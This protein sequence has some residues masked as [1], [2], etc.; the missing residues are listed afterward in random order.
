MLHGFTCRL[1]GIR[2]MDKVFI[3]GGERTPVGKT[4]GMLN[5]FLPE[6]LA[7]LVLNGVID[8][9][10][11]SP[12]EVDHVI[13]G[14]VW[15]PGGNIAR[16]S[17]LEAGWPYE[18]PGTTIDFQCGSGLSAVTIGANQI[19]A[20]Q[21]DLVIAGGVESSSMAPVRKFNVRD[22]RFRGEGFYERAPFSIPLVGDPEMG[23]GAE[24]LAGLMA[25]SREEMDRLA[26]ES[27][28]RASRTQNEGLLR[29]II[30]P[31]NVNGKMVSNDECIRP[32]MNMRLLERMPAAF[33]QGGKV[34][35]GNACLK[36]DGA[37]AVLLASGRAI[38]K[39]N[40][41]PEAVILHQAISGCDPN[42]FPLGPVLSVKKALE[43]ANKKL[44]EI[45]AFEINE[46]F[47]VKVLACCQ[48][49]SISL[50]KT[51]ILGG[52]LAYGHPYG[53]SGAIILLHLL[54][55]LRKIN[56]RLGIAAIGAAGGQ[57][58]AV[59]VERCC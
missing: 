23:Q 39:F 59:L 4:G 57:G 7:G 32:R 25:I 19:A 12:G 13:L 47:A 58:V 29:D 17:V 1:K 31:V 28:R 38:N 34:T 6:Q 20:G 56:G 54:R 18:I 21:A 53:A 52:A 10:G 14:N 2:R 55:A 5:V 26:L 41:K 49:L 9:F 8:K 40:L 42:V 22:P 15:G 33:V 44:D 50:D 3:V 30:L 24:N 27:H 48:K 43:K 11:I 37:A 46:A 51:N 45:D 36:H 35:A 16:V